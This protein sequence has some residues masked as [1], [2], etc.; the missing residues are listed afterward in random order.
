MLTTDNTIMVELISILISFSF[1]LMAQKP[2]RLSSL[3]LQ[4][5]LLMFPHSTLP[6]N[7]AKTTLLS[8]QQ[9][10]A[11]VGG[12][13]EDPLIRAIK[14]TPLSSSSTYAAEGVRVVADVVGGGVI[15]WDVPF[16]SSSALPVLSADSGA[17]NGLTPLPAVQ[18]RI[19]S[20]AGSESSA[21]QLVVAVTPD[22][23]VLRHSNRVEGDLETSPISV[24]S[25]EEAIDTAAARFVHTISAATGRVEIFEPSNSHRL[26]A[27]AQFDPA[28]EEIAAVAYPVADDVVFSRLAV[29]GTKH[30]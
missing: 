28:V 24:V 27:S 16:S 9:L 1:R 11:A 19:L 15:V 7:T 3:Q 30:F 10:I 6:I 14:L 20:Q 26:V 18:G 5:H 2:R 4:A 29:L 12:G 22:H 13:Q 8:S 21:D 23:V 17:L 25:F